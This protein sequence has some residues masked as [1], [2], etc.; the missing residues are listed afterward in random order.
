M[1]RDICELCD[2]VYSSTSECSG[3]YISS[4]QIEELECLVQ[5]EDEDAIS[6]MYGWFK[7]NCRPT[8]VCRQCREKEDFI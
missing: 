8:D 3:F 6:Y 2:D 5:N 4:T 1:S 7:K